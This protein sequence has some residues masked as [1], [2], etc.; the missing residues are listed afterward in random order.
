MKTGGPSPNLTS[1][2]SGFPGYK[3]DN[4]YVKP[5]DKHS[6]ANFP[7][8]SRTTY[9]NSFSLNKPTTKPVK[10]KLY[11]NLK[12][13]S[14]WLGET[15]YGKNYRQPNPEDFAQKYKMTEKL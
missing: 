9:G 4:Q 5:T 6:R 8:M 2:S 14:V 1:Y 15:S 7:L 13:G 10:E 11:D 12:S 3:G